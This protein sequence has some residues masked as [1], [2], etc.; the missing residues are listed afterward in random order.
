MIAAQ[1][2]RK[3]PPNT[4]FQL[5]ASREIVLFL[6]WFCAARLPQLNANPFGGSYQARC[7]REQYVIHY[8]ISA[9]AILINN[10]CLLHIKQ[11]ALTSQPI[12]IYLFYM[13]SSA[14]YSNA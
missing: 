14:V 8:H 3:P 5:T 9:T 10:L 6:T 4:A 13:L 2:F 11:T 12:R 1:T 7:L